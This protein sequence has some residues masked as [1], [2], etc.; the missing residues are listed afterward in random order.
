MP[1]WAWH[2]CS[3]VRHYDTNAIMKQFL[4]DRDAVRI[5]AFWLEDCFDRNYSVNEWTH[6]YVS[7]IIESTWVSHMWYWE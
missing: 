2:D 6:I 5:V 7:V 3:L 4:K 1:N